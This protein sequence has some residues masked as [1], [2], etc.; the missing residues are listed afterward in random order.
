MVLV[1]YL[2]WIALDLVLEYA[3][4]SFLKTVT[5]F[6]MPFKSLHDLDNSEGTLQLRQGEFARL[7]IP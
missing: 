1:L 2:W 7:E 5:P 4:H 3:C 6:N